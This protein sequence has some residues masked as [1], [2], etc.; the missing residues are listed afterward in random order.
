MQN[1]SLPI[2]F[3]KDTRI[4]MS[5]TLAFEPLQFFEL[6]PEMTHILYDKLANCAGALRIRDACHLLRLFELK[7]MGMELFRFMESLPID[8]RERIH[9]KA[10]LL[11]CQSKCEAHQDTMRE[12]AKQLRVLDQITMADVSLVRLELDT[13]CNEALQA[14]RALRDHM[15]VLLA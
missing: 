2:S 3:D 15:D 11:M 8:I 12:L 5:W 13:K 10:E 6:S 1:F 7:H 9:K 4:D 14:I